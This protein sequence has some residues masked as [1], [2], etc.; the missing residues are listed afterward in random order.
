MVD[1]PAAPSFA[2]PEDDGSGSDDGDDDYWQ[3]PKS[4]RI[5]LNAAVCCLVC[6]TLMCKCSVP[7]AAVIEKLERMRELGEKARLRPGL[8]RKELRLL[9]KFYSERGLRRRVKLMDHP[10]V[11]HALNMIWQ[12][13][14]TDGS[15]LIERSAQPPSAPFVPCPTLQYSKTYRCS[16]CR[17]THTHTQG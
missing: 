6:T 2:E 9:D 16:C 11:V 7:C 4:T 1:D 3:Q 15:N 17:H 13:A 12:A 14:D 10:E 5:S 8:T